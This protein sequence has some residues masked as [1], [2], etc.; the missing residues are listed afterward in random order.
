MTGAD[1]AADQAPSIDGDDDIGLDATLPV[2]TERLQ[3]LLD[4]DTAKVAVK[5]SFRCYDIPFVAHAIEEADGPKLKLSG[6]VGAQPFTAESRE[7][8]EMVKTVLHA[9]QAA[10]SHASR[11]PGAT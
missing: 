8:R 6:Y 11:S 7:A 3:L 1:M 5:I 9:T 10:R 2:T 4:A